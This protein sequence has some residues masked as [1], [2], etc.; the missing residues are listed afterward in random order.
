MAH[1]CLVVNGLVVTG[2]QDAPKVFKNVSC[3]NTLSDA[4]KMEYGWFP[5]EVVQPD[6]DPRSQT[7]TGP[8]YT[9][10]ADDVLAVWTVQDR[11]LATVKA[12]LVGRVKTNAGEKLAP[13]DYL[14]IRASEPG[15]EPAP[16]GILEYRAS[17]RAYSNTLEDG[18]NASATAA[19]AVNIY[20]SAVWPT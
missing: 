3:F 1:H 14:S 18:I 9:V 16:Q 11:D 15:G 8:V 20:E 5:T 17:V 4:A 19:D 12:E 7:R 6:F 2:P 10:R 13:T